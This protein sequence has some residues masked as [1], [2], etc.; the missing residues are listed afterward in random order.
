MDFVIELGQWL[1]L[2]PL[3]GG[4][5][6][7]IPQLAVYTTCIPLI[8]CLLGGYMLPTTF[9]GNQKQPLIGCFTNFVLHSLKLRFFAPENGWLEYDPFLLGRPMFKGYASFKEGSKFEKVIEKYHS[10]LGVANFFCN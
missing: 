2:V 9:Y 4:R 1:F 6:H 8:Y 5:W 3:K 7:I 10:Y